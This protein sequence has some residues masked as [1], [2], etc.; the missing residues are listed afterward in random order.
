MFA[1]GLDSHSILDG[2]TDLTCFIASDSLNRSFANF[3]KKV[4]SIED[5]DRQYTNGE[6]RND[7]PVW[8][9]IL[10]NGACCLGR[11]RPISNRRADNAAASI[12]L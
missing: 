8:A 9:K 5:G 12:I 6:Y 4:D 7:S 10:L 11:S 2:E 1:P 3:S